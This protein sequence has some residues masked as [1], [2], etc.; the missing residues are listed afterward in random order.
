MESVSPDTQV[1]RGLMRYRSRVGG[2]EGS[3]G[4]SKSTA[5]SLHHLPRLPP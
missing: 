2:V 3:D 4:D 5:H 1:E